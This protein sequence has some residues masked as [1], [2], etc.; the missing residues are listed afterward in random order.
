MITVL[1]DGQCDEEQLR[2]R[3]TI[4]RNSVGKPWLALGQGASFVEGD[5]SERAEVFERTAIFAPRCNRALIYRSKLLHCAAVPNGV[6]LSAD[7]RT[8][9]LTVAS[10]LTAR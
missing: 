5:R 1:L 9:R 10:F 2:F 7:P 8:G 4:S 3:N 6:A